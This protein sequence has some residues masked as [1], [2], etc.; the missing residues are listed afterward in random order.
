MTL[1]V[2][3]SADFD[4]PG[5]GIGHGRLDRVDTAREIRERELRS[6]PAPGLAPGR[7]SSVQTM[8]QLGFGSGVHRQRHGHL[9]P[10]PEGLLG[11]RRGDG[12]LCRGERC[13][14]FGLRG[15]RR[16]RPGAVWPRMPACPGEARGE[17]LLRTRNGLIGEMHHALRVGPLVDD[18]APGPRKV[19]AR[20]PTRRPR[21][22]ERQRCIIPEHSPI[23][24]R[25][26]NWVTA[27]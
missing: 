17:H 20:M 19:S 4:S 1:K 3:A 11:A 2:T 12:E 23:P 22:Q 24:S 15:S 9:T 27:A 6:P 14:G 8:V 7:R 13:C 25:P 26:Q 10:R 5:A 21:I 18:Q 16:C